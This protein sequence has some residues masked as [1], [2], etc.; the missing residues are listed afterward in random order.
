MD[1]V[2]LRQYFFL[3]CAMIFFQ[4]CSITEIFYIFAK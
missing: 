3:C 1:N 4:N 2:P